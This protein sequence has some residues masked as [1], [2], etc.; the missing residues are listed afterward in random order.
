[1]ESGHGDFARAAERYGAI[2]ESYNAAALRFAITELDTARI[3]YEAA[4][5]TRDQSRFFNCVR[6]AHTA[7]RAALRTCK[8][9]RV[10]DEEQSMMARQMAWLRSL[11]ERVKS[12]AADKSQFESYPGC[13]SPW[14]SVNIG[15][16]KG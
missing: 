16:R 2:R 9:W 12:K 13:P 15:Q 1:M 6:S 11:F 10:N 7:V 14:G 4:L 3:F 5:T 8:L